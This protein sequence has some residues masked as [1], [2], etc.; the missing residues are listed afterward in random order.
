M[1][2]KSSSSARGDTGAP[3]RR[4]TTKKAAAPAPV[5]TDVEHV[6]TEPARNRSEEERPSTSRAERHDADDSGF[7]AGLDIPESA[8]DFEP[9]DDSRMDFHPREASRDESDE[10]DVE[11]TRDEFDNRGGGGG[12]PEEHDHKR[13]RRRRRRRRGGQGE[14]QPQ[15]QTPQPQQSQQRQQQRGP[16][17][18]H[19]GHQ[20][21]Q[22]HREHGQNREQNGRERDTPSIGT[23]EGI[24]ELHPKG[25]G[26]LRDPKNNY[27]SV[28]NDTFVS[29]TLIE[30][31][32][33]REGVL[34]KGEAS[35]GIKGQGPRLKN[36]ETVDGRSV[37][38]YMKIRPFDELTPINPFEQIK[39]ETGA[40][41][42]TMRVM[43]LL[44]PIG[45]GQRALIVAPPRTG[46][47]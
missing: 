22:G 33:L 25:Y 32:R 44:C 4:R 42:V 6:E 45:K 23:V 26:F 14:G 7:A 18:R 46:K 37:E 13:R 30:K 20:G 35:A 1:A 10:G 40:A 29:S 3:K 8:L 34:L 9:A 19:Q 27:A 31:N 11:Q 2:A 15:G 36:I 21:H 17:G 47:T 24:L 16:R 41:P 28:K 43:D 5:E 12:T 39:L 38:D